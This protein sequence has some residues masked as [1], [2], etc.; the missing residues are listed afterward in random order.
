M[1]QYR[2]FLEISSVFSI[3]LNLA[4]ANLIWKKELYF[5][6]SSPI[7]PL[8]QYIFVK[9]LSFLDILEQ[10]L[11]VW[12]RLQAYVCALFPPFRTTGNKLN[13]KCFFSTDLSI[14]PLN[15]ILL[16]WLK[17]LHF[18][19]RY[20]LDKAKHFFYEI[21]VNFIWKLSLYF[22]LYSKADVRQFTAQPHFHFVI[23]F[24]ILLNWIFL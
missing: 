3:K 20:I 10:N 23:N 2:A 6:I 9:H 16:S 13:F 15:C 17:C 24:V 21:F 22:V 18:Q 4:T 11:H 1:I 14:F 12:L 19:D 5:T 8:V 7:L